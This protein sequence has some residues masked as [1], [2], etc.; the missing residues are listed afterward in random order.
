M[1]DERLEKILGAV[2]NRLGVN[3]TK[4]DPLFSLVVLNKEVLKE[5]FQPLED[6]ISSLR[7]DVESAVSRLDSA[8]QEHE[9]K[10][11]ILAGQALSRYEDIENACNGLTNA[12]GA[13]IE[14]QRQ[15]LKALASELTAAAAEKAVIDAVEKSITSLE[16]ESNAQAKRYREAVLSLVGEVEKNRDSSLQS[17]K[18]AVASLHEA[19][20]ACIEASK[21]DS[22][23]FIYGGV[24]VGLIAVISISAAMVLSDTIRGGPV[25]TPQTLKNAKLGEQFTK[26]FIYLD[27]ASQQKVNDAL[28]RIEQPK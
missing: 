26:S 12:F 7:S 4:D 1:D 19:Q 5:T 21:K 16:S 14:K 9:R 15:Q 28:A 6:S 25:A 3:I 27:P 2:Q 10:F 23:R 8:G 18:L 11:N 22:K 20:K 13:A 17:I 24:F